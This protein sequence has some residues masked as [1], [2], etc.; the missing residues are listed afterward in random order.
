MPR[1][2][3]GP[4]L[5]LRRNWPDGRPAAWIIA[6]V[7]TDAERTA[8]RDSALM[9]L[10]ETKDAALA[11]YLA[12][13]HD[14]RPKSGRSA[15]EALVADCLT[16]YVEKKEKRFTPAATDKRGIS[17]QK[18]DRTI[19]RRLTEFFGLLTV[20]EVSGEL[21][22]AYAEQRGS[23]SSARRELSFLAAA[24]N[25][26]NK[27][28][29]GMS[30]VFSPVLPEALPARDRW[31]TRQEAARLL[32]AAWRARQKNWGGEDGRYVGKHVARFI[33]V[34]CTPNEG[35]GGLRC[36][37]DSRHRP[38]PCRSR[39]RAV[40]QESLGCPR[41]EQAATDRRSSAAVARAHAAL[42][43][44]RRFK[45]LSG[46]MVWQAGEERLPG[47]HRSP[48]RGRAG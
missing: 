12:R 35:R 9:R 28:K 19:A 10:S 6:T 36:G 1:Q 38:R 18:E 21:Q 25:S 7:L 24:I 48:R 14:P 39:Q 31:L 16:V 32:R 33:L 40:P 3:K 42:A 8:A 13:K 5:F 26:Y 27:K 45:S 22:E 41:H 4:Y 30:M 2:A 29:G 23:Q 15:N 47:L 11:K 20:G 44:P 34:G 17:R 43:A 46:R 37:A